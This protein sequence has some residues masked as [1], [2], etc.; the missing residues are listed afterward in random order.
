LAVFGALDTAGT[1]ADFFAGMSTS[2]NVGKGTGWDTRKNA[3]GR[4]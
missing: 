2:K 3:K 1:L 4:R